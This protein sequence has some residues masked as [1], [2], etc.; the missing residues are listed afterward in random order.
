MFKSNER[1]L[2]IVY[3]KL[4]PRYQAKIR[5]TLDLFSK[6]SSVDLTVQEV[7]FSF[8]MS[9]MTVQ[10]EATKHADYQKLKYV[11]YL[12][13]IARVA[14]AKHLEDEGTPLAVK[15]E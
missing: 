1:G 2:K 3:D 8:G 7:T 6:G 9:K 14:Y 15:V 10:D 11:E 13:F 5:D 4:F 12:E